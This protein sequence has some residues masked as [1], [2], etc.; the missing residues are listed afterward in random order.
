MSYTQKTN[1]NEKKAKSPKKKRMSDGKDITPIFALNKEDNEVGFAEEFRDK[2]RT[3]FEH[4]D[5]DG[6]K[7][8]NFPELAAL[9]VA[10]SGDILT[11]DMYVMACRALGCPPSQGLSL[12][13]LKLTYASEGANIG[14]YSG[15]HKK[16][17][18][19][20]SPALDSY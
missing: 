4:F 15:W 1:E 2:V 20:F 9:Q 11:E 7:Y 12:D 13:A 19:S 14:A 17:S 5:K 3:L 16:N 18:F 8:L 6:D 10:T